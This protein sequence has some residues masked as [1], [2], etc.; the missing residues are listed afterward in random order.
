MRVSPAKNIQ[1]PPSRPAV[2]LD[3]PI[4]DLSLSRRARNA[5]RKAGYETVR[6]LVQGDGANIIRQLGVITREEV[7]NALRE[8]GLGVP[9]A[10]VEVRRERI[11]GISDELAR[12]REQIDVTSRHLQARVERLEARLRKLDS[13]FNASPIDEN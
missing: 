8:H 3:S 5:L 4:E 1:L 11:S 7:V 10:L 13:T 12:L 2:H 9:M 6:S